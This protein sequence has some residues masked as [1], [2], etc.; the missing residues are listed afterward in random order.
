MREKGV[1]FGKDGYGYSLLI[2]SE[3]P[4]GKGVSSSAAIEVATMQALAAAVDLMLEP[5]E[6]AML[7]QKAENLVVGAPCGV[8]DQMASA[9]GKKGE[10]MA[11]ICRPAEVIESVPIPSGVA[12]WGVDSG[13]RHSVGGADYGSVRVGAFM[14]KK[15]IKDNAAEEAGTA[16]PLIP[17]IS[18]IILVLF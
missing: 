5:R 17:V 16:L 6:L 1:L 7:C 2:S 12:F 14:G 13:I 15:I 11:M 9:C 8:M 18:Q 4:E 10:L 3:V